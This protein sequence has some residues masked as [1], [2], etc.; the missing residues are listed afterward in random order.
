VI[1]G[2]RSALLHTTPT[3]WRTIGVSCLAG[4]VLFVGGVLYFR[5]VEPRFADV[6]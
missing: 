2:F 6:A 4:C 5:H 1:E 3:P